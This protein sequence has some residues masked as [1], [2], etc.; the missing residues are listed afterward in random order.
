MATRFTETFHDDGQTDMYEALRA[1]S[2]VGFNGPMRPDHAPVMDGEANTDPMYM[3]LGRLFAIGYIK[4][5]LEGV[6]HLE[7]TA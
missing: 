2:E 3:H 7:R 1:Y 4:G 5:M 6:D